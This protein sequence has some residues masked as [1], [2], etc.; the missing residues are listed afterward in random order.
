V[1]PV[2]CIDETARFRDGEKGFGE[3][4]VHDFFAR[5]DLS[6]SSILTTQKYRLLLSKATLRLQ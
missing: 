4:Y 2:G 5:G 1:Q 3:V 6:D